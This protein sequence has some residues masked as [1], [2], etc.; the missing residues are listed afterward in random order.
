MVVGGR[1]VVG[2]ETVGQ[3]FIRGIGYFFGGRHR[4]EK[5]LPNLKFSPEN[6]IYYGK[7]AETIQQVKDEYNIDIVS[8]VSFEENGEN[9]NNLP[10]REEDILIVT[11]TIAQLP[12]FYLV[13]P[14]GPKKI[15]LTRT[16][17]SAGSEGAGGL[18]GEGRVILYTAERFSPKRQMGGYLGKLYE[19][20]G[21]HL[22]AITVHEWTHTFVEYF[23][24]LDSEWVAKM[25]WV[26]DIGKKEPQERWK[27]TDPES[28][29]HEADADIFPWEDMAVSAGLMLVNPK[30]LSGNRLH[31]FL[32]NPYYTEWPVVKKY[33]DELIMDRI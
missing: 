16:P 15:I 13:N 26:E 24:K 12:P 23:N 1:F 14:E 7:T 3:L 29:I 18:N 22:K 11:E 5:P 31:F 21:D 2:P 30:V 20:Q 4:G 33:R 6:I 32:E 17:G 19:S 27:N 8:P 10:W 25:G 28:L 9:K